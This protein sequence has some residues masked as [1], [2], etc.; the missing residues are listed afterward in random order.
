[1]I[2]QQLPNSYSHIFLQD[3][4][5]NTEVLV[6]PR[7]NTPFIKLSSSEKKMVIKG[8]SD[9][10]NIHLL[11]API[12]KK[13]ANCLEDSSAFTLNLFFTKMNA[14][15]IKILFSLFKTVRNSIAAGTDV[16][17]YWGVESTD[18]HLREIGKD[19]AEIYDLDMQY[20]EVSTEVEVD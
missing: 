9:K 7:S 15:T 20:Y 3:L 8:A 17:V 1:M 5:K 14:S 19:F 4:S 18:N 10:E 16:S 2:A 13:L 12:L 11:Y 6:E